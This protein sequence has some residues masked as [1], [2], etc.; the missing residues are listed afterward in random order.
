MILFKWI[1]YHKINTD[2]IASQAIFQIKTENIQPFFV[3]ISICLTTQNSLTFNGRKTDETK[4]F[5]NQSLFQFKIDGGDVAG[6]EAFGSIF[7]FISLKVS[8]LPSFH[9]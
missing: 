2:R 1:S 3:R 6:Q 4:I 7:N 5:F 9:D 8:D